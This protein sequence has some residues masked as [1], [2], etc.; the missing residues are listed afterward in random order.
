VA[1]YAN[2]KQTETYDRDQV[3]AFHRTM[4]IR[5]KFRFKNRT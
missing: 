5:T 2:P 4:K 3:E 1:G